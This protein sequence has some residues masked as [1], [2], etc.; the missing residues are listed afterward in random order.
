MK[1]Y[2]I[3]EKSQQEDHRDQSRI[4]WSEYNKSEYQMVHT[5]IQ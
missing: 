1:W 3:K 4:Q 2:L 5:I